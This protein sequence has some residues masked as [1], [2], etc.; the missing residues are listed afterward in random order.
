M[1]GVSSRSPARGRRAS[2]VS[3]RLILGLA[4]L[5]GCGHVASEETN[6]GLGEID[7]AER[8]VERMEGDGTAVDGDVRIV[9]PDCDVKVEGKC[10]ESTALVAEAGESTESAGESAGDA[11][12]V[13]VEIVANVGECSGRRF[14]KCR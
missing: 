13:A 12:D 8:V 5:H 10:G 7:A 14:K 9:V 3:F 4:L 6:G 1:R 2:S 11:V